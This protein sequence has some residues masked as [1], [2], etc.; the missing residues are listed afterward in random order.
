MHFN[1]DDNYKTVYGGALSIMVYGFM[2]WYTGLKAYN[3]TIHHNPYILSL[4]RAIDYQKDEIAS[5]K[6]LLNETT[7]VHYEV[8]D[9][10]FT[11][12]DYEES[13]KY[14]TLTY[15]QVTKYKDENGAVISDTE[16]F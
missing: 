12:Y 3:M 16:P 9:N 8:I 4:G 10:L 2:V 13:K 15:N 6:V 7:K 14:I 11:R 1:G 5:T